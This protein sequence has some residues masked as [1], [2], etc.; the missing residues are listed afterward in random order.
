MQWL[1]HG[2]TNLLHHDRFTFRIE[3][4]AKSLRAQIQDS[5]LGCFLHKGD[6]KANGC[7]NYEYDPDCKFPVVAVLCNDICANKRAESRTK[8]RG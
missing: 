8:E 4:A 3:V 6:C 7:Q 5:A 2:F 1:Q